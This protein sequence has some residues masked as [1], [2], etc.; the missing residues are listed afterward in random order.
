MQD[1][2]P[3][4]IHFAAVGGTGGIADTCRLYKTLQIPI[5]I[6]ADL[7]IVTSQDRMKK[8]LSLIGGAREKKLLTQSM[9]IAKRIKE[10]PPTVAPSDVRAGLEEALK[11]G[12]NWASDDDTP[13]RS[14]LNEIVQALDR[15]RRLKRGGLV[16][17]PDNLREPLAELVSDLRGVGLFVVPVGELEEWL[18]GHGLLASKT[19]KW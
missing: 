1:E 4:A 5:A 12:M 16:G 15:M 17:L 9:D 11:S 2:F 6:I 14:R 13:L 7:D 8:V 18:G 19:N 3:F 10:L